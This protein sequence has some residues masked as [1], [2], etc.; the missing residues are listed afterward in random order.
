MIPFVENG[1]KHGTSQTLE[2]PWIRLKIYAEDD[3][4]HFLLNNSK[5]SLAPQHNPKSGIGL[6]NVE[7]RLGLIY[8]NQHF[9]QIE[10]DAESIFRAYA[11]ADRVKS[12][13]AG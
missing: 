9:L 2:H 1:F 7:K 4:L 11:N 8:P 3:T 6:H 13:C 12:S 10:T 5:P